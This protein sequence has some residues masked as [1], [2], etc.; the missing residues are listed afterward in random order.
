MHICG[1]RKNGTEEPIFQGRKREADIGSGH[2]DILGEG[3][4]NWEIS[5][6]IYTLPCVNQMTSG[7][8]M[9]SPGSSAWCS[10]MT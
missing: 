2:V 1:I 7:K 6:D 4:M 8:L 9:D 10:V 5:I 3:G